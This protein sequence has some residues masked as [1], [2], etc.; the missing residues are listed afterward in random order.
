[1]DGKY[2][3]AWCED[4]VLAV[5]GKPTLGIKINEEAAN[6]AVFDLPFGITIPYHIVYPFQGD[7]VAVEVVVNTIDKVEKP[8]P[9][10]VTVTV[11]GVATEYE[12]GAEVTLHAPQILKNG[13]NFFVFKN[14]VAEGVELT[15]ATAQDITFVVPANDVVLTTNR[16]LHGDVD[17]NGKLT[18][19]DAI[20]LKK[21]IKNPASL[22]EQQKATA[23]GDVDLN[24]KV[25]A[26]DYIAEKRKLKEK[27]NYN[28]SKYEVVEVEA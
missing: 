22:T 12:I 23:N 14:W 26:T 10:T 1:V 6:I 4:D 17:N 25:T 2:P 18:A 9:T 8:A 15:D 28:Y 19:T 16:Y 13:V 20:L 11:D 7:D 5:N 27:E 21:L 24:G 3:V